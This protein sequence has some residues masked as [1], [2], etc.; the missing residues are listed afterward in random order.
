MRVTAFAPTAA[1]TSQRRMPFL[2]ASRGWIIV[3]R[4]L[5][6]YL[7]YRW[8]SVTLRQ[9]HS[10]GGCAWSLPSPP[11]TCRPMRPHSLGSGVP[12]TRSFA[13][14]TATVRNEFCRV[15]VSQSCLVWRPGPRSVLDARRG[16]ALALRGDGFLAALVHQ[17]RGD[18]DG[19]I[20]RAAFVPSC[21]F[22]IQRHPP[23][24]QLHRQLSGKRH[25]H[26]RLTVIEEL[27]R[28]KKGNEDVNFHARA[29]LRRL[30]P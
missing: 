26:P 7:V 9:R 10:G 12:P 28:F 6:L 23:R 18:L 15:K 4:L 17:H 8:I 27:D 19:A 22:W 30:A 5:V 16:G 1:T 20:L 3:G 13:P 29:F 25:R 11:D 2:P 14:S 24:L 21:S